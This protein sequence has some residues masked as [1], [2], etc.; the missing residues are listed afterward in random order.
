[1][2]DLDAPVQV[3]FNGN[4][5]FDGLVDRSR[6]TMEKTLAERGDPSGVFT[7]EVTVDFAQGPIQ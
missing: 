7:A 6:A 5:Y 2:V 1:M 4:L 3:Y